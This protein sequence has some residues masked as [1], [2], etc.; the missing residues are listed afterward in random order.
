MCVYYDFVLKTLNYSWKLV[1]II[2]CYCFVF[3]FYYWLSWFVQFNV[4]EWR[5]RNVQAF[6]RYI[7]TCVFKCLK[8]VNCC[9]NTLYNGHGRD[10]NRKNHQPFAKSRLPFLD[11][12]IIHQSRKSI[13][14]PIFHYLY[15]PF[16]SYKFLFFF[17]YFFCLIMIRFYESTINETRIPNK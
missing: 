13:N 3:R 2:C 14:E 12:H 15:F 10:G 16:S 17:L 8:P 9:K 11:R 5:F 1:A 4:S 6:P 7:H